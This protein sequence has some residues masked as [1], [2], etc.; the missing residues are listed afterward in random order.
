MLFLTNSFSTGGVETHI[1]SLA[2]ALLQRGYFVAVASAGGTLE[3]ELAQRG[4]LHIY[5]PL[6]ARRA[7]G[8][9]LA[10]R[11]LIQAVKEY[12]FDITTV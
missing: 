8:L 12:S 9:V 6:N 4:I 5:L 2:E 10:R 1:L 7:D 3:S 11:L